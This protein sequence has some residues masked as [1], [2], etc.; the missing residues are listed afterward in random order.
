MYKYA[1]I[2]VAINGTDLL[3][4]ASSHLNTL[5][6]NGTIDSVQLTE[7]ENMI[8]GS[9][10][11]HVIDNVQLKLT[12]NSNGQ[13]QSTPTTNLPNITFTDTFNSCSCLPADWA[14]TTGDGVA[15]ACC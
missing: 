1:D 13:A 7:I 3:S 15:D 4:L 8:L 9:S 2:T 11:S 10:V 14:D 5:L 6:N 12:I